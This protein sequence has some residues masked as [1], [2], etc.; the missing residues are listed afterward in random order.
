MLSALKHKVYT[1]PF[2]KTAISL[3]A[4]ILI[5]IFSNTFVSDITASGHVDWSSTYRSTSFYLLVVSAG[6]TLLF[7]KW[8]HAFETEI[9]NFRDT[10]YCRA[11][12]LSRLLPEQIEK[13]RQKIK[14][15]ETGEFQAAMREI[16]K[17][18][19]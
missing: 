18:L 9:Q 16:Q 5:G 2:L 7:H 19:K 6:A 11:Y 17:V 13:S 1:S 15:G 4:S 14:D 8:L 12:A 10:E 3:T